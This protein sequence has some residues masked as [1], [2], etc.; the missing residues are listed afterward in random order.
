MF[1]S[2]QQLVCATPSIRGTLQCFEVITTSRE[3]SC[4]LSE[5]YRLIAVTISLIYVRD[6]D[7]VIQWLWCAI[8]HMLMCGWAYGVGPTTILCFLAINSL[9]TICKIVSGYTSCGGLAIS[10]VVYKV[11]DY[12]TVLCS[13]KPLL[14]ARRHKV[15]NGWRGSEAWTA[16][17]PA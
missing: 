5:F 3:L 10:S 1:S 6:F 17:L 13:L 9:P 4:P 15:G 12:P 14:I 8:N 7:W 11:N 2:C 16:W